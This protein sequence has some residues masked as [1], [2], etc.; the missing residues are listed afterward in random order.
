MSNWHKLRR[1]W[2][3]PGM[4]WA[5]ILATQWGPASVYARQADGLATPMMQAAAPLAPGCERGG[6]TKGLMIVIG[7]RRGQV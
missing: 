2:V 4:G 1:M 7:L 5:C 6:G 3:F